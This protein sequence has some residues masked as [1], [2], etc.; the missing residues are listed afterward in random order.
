ML[1]PGP[2]FE[3]VHVCNETMQCAWQFDAHAWSTTC[4]AEC[5]S[6][7]DLDCCITLTSGDGGSI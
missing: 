2:M 5:L 7:R 6:L 3:E 1:R 4:W